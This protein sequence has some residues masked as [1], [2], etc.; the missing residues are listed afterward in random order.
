M[1]RVAVSVLNNG[2]RTVCVVLLLSVLWIATLQN[3]EAWQYLKHLDVSS[4]RILARKE[5]Q[6][7]LS[8]IYKSSNVVKDEQHVRRCRIVNDSSAI[9]K[10]KAQIE[11]DC[12]RTKTSPPVQ[13]CVYNEGSDMYISHDIIHTGTWEPHVLHDIQYQ[14][15]RHPDAGFIDLGANIGYYSLIAAEMGHRVTAVEPL[16]SSVDRLLAGI[17]LMK[18][19][20]KITVVFNAVGGQRSPGEVK[21]SGNNQGDTR[22]QPGYRPCVGSCSQATDIILL[23]D[24]MEVIAFN[25]CIIKMDIQGYESEVILRS[26]KLLQTLHVLYIFMEWGLFTSSSN[27]NSTRVQAQGMISKLLALNYRPYALSVDG[28]QTLDVAYWDA[29]PFDIV[30]HKLP[31]DLDLQILLRNHFIHWPPG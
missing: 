19:Q 17:K 22:I 25:S 14:L 1:L 26:E 13:V 24:L 18:L 11:F 12:V 7:S 2:S 8:P 6:E 21:I 29:W 10:T 27:D 3:L 23:D 30:W 31:S 5:D 16:A 28:G 4:V 20:S 9:S 15:K